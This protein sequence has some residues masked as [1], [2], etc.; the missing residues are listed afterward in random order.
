MKRRV[1]ILVNHEVVIYNFRLELVERLL[2]EGYEVHISTPSGKR[3]E[4]LRELGAIVHDICFERHG[5]NPVSE[6]RLLLEYRRLIKEVKPLIVLGYTIK[7]NIYGAIASR[8]QGVPF[9]ANITGLG[10]SVEN[11][12]LS[13][14][15]TVLM[16]K[17]S[18]GTKQGKIQRVFFQNHDNREFFEEHIIAID[19]HAILPGSGVNTS[20]FPFTPLPMC[21]NGKIGSP[22]RFAFISRIM[23]EKGI[24]VYLSATEVV[25]AEYPCTEFHVCGFFESEYDRKKMDEL[26]EKGIVIYEGNIENVSNFMSRMHCIVHP[27]Y[28]PEGLSNVLLEACST[29]RPIITTDRAG[30]REVCHDGSNGFIVNERDAVDLSKKM[31]DFIQLDFSIKQTMGME[32]RQ[33]VEENFDRK[34]VVEAYLNEV[35]NAEKKDEHMTQCR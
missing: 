33:I 20:R 16:Y 13:Q 34:I 7:P 25:K 4:K 11:G 31:I 15:L 10:T 24:D 29:G 3:V 27:S 12:G 30:C 19:K 1:L 35:K 23:E 2:A 18:F 32:G 22:I 9:V 6:V 17:W 26:I 8:M 14:M 28:Y 5:M 21:G